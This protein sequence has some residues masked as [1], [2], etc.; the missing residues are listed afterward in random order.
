VHSPFCTHPGVC[1]LCLLV[2]QWLSASL[3]PSQREEVVRF[4]TDPSKE[5]STVVARLEDQQKNSVFA[6][7]GLLAGDLLQHCLQ[8][9]FAVDYGVP[10]SDRKK[11]L[12]VPYT[13]ADT[14]S[15]RSEFAQPDK[16]RT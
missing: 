13:A 14:P 10:S 8:L 16:V 11:R 4:V 15:P 6:M 5:E 2:F 1:A 7:R 3:S 12:A 9:R